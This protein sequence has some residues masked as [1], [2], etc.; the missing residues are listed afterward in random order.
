M[1]Y[2]TPDELP[3]TYKCRRL[4]IP[5]DVQWLEIVNGALSELLKAR[6]FEEFGDVTPQQ[7]SEVFTEMFYEYLQGEACLL[8]SIQLYA[9]TL[10]DGVLP[11]DGDNYLRTDY[12]QLYAM[13]S[14]TFITDADN[15]VTPTLYAGDDMKYG[16]VAR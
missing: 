1:G 6:N 2:L 9:G 8:G 4:R 14:P 7:A 13:L 5:D 11:C 15:F 3:T 16:I 12:P 10:P